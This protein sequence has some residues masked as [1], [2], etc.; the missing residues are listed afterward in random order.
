MYAAMENK[1][2]IL[3]KMLDLGCDVQ[4]MNKELYSTLHLASMYSR[5][6]TVK[7]L[8]NKKAD[9]VLQGGVSFSKFEQLFRMNLPLLPSCRNETLF[10]FC[11]AAEKSIKRS[12]GLL[13][14]HISCIANTEGLTAR[15]SQNHQAH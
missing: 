14:A 12:L 4:A 8:L 9:P 10:V 6:E 3:E 13:E 7:L 11:F 1:T 5:E 15:N 2:T